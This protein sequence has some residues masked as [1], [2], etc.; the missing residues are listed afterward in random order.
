MLQRIISNITSSS[1]SSSFV[2]LEIEYHSGIYSKKELTCMRFINKCHRVWRSEGQKGQEGEATFFILCNKLFVGKIWWMI[3][4]WN[5]VNLISP[6]ALNGRRWILVKSLFSTLKVGGGRSSRLSRILY[7]VLH[8][9][10][11]IEVGGVTGSLEPSCDTFFQ[12][13]GIEERMLQY[14]KQ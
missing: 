5:I 14:C 9:S 10:E 11:Q 7:S 6:V 4:F 3:L 1:G 13:W 8:D 2:L 12:F